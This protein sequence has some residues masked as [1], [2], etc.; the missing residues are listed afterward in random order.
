V[1]NYNCDV[2]Q[3]KK[4]LKLIGVILF[5]AVSAA[6]TTACAPNDGDKND[7]YYEQ[8]QPRHPA[9]DKGDSSE[10]ALKAQD[11]ADDAAEDAKDGYVKAA[12]ERENVDASEMPSQTIAASGP[13]EVGAAK[14]QEIKNVNAGPHALVQPKQ[15]NFKKVSIKP[16]KAQGAAPTLLASANPKDMEQLQSRT[17]GEEDVTPSQHVPNLTQ[18]APDQKINLSYNQELMKLGKAA[19]KDMS[20]VCGGTKVMRTNVV[21]HYY[22][23]RMDHFSEFTCHQMEGTCHFKQKGTWY[24]ANYGKKSMPLRDARCKSGYGYGLPTNCVHPCRTLAASKRFHKP[25]EVIFFPNLVGMKC[26]T[27]KNAMI[28]DGFMVVND[29]GSPKHF[30]REGRFDFFWGECHKFGNGLCFD[31]GIAISQALSTSRYCRVWRTQDPTHNV[32]A[33]VKVYAAIN[34]EARQGDDGNASVASLETWI[35]YH[36]RERKH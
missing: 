22:V 31:G 7:I 14:P 20:I 29:T 17:V 6:V 8:A 18:T 2:A 32:D 21:T 9:S 28:H 11:A 13:E 24:I 1:K 36:T 3:I 15:I 26:G 19:Q 23:P 33:K 16:L 35:N 30:N 12:E 4:P 25:G 27:G 34:Q 5:F 10:A